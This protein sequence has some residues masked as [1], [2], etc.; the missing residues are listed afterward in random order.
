MKVLLVDDHLLL[1]TGFKS[2]VEKKENID[3]EIFAG[4]L[5]LEDFSNHVSSNK[6]DILILDINLKKIST[7]D[8]LELS[9]KILEKFP[10][11]KIVLLTGYDNE[12][13]KIQAKKI[14][15]KA[16]I[17]KN[18]E[19]SEFLQILQMV[20]NGENLMKD[21]IKSI[22]TEREIEI[23]VL[24]SKGYSRDQLAKKL[25]IST[26]TLGNHLHS[27]YEK[28]EVY[29]V[30]EMIEKATHLGYIKNNIF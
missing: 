25:F 15:I 5:N 23:M 16:F 8:G 28:L 24:Y 13:F 30:Q 20:Y 21:K 11:Q 3:L 26:R 17:D 22:L 9:E 14:G 2:L 18:I 4:N 7:L 19:I 27:I 29:N 12:A 6:Y 1:A 10:E